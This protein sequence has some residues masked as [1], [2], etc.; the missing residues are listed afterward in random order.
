MS[1]LRCTV[2]SRLHFFCHP[3]HITEKWKLFPSDLSKKA[4]S[5]SS[6][7]K[8][9]KKRCQSALPLPIK[10]RLE[11]VCLSPAATKCRGALFWQRQAQSAAARARSEEHTSELQSRFD[12]V[13]RL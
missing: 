10:A 8:E 4:A 5:K 9:W 6:S 3:V 11:R 7:E 13:C 1:H 2:Q 12:I